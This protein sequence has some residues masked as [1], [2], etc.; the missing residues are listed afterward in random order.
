MGFP[1]AQPPPGETKRAP[2]SS[3]GASPTASPDRA[4]GLGCASTAPRQRQ[5]S[6]PPAAPPASPW[7]RSF[8]DRRAPA[9]GSPAG[10]RRQPRRFTRPRPR[11]RVLP[12]CHGPADTYR[13][14]PGGN[15]GG[16]NNERW[17]QKPR[18]K[19][20][21]RIVRRPLRPA[22]SMSY[23]VLKRKFTACREPEMH[24]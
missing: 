10:S 3:R 16:T 4:H 15:F 1:A 19:P 13:E 11:A 21:R 2:A 14:P 22:R 20:L 9:S 8:A 18:L 24:R 23:G 17:P 12:V 7:C 5:R 6:K